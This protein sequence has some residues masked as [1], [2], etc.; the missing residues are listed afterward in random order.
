MVF[1]DVLL[2]DIIFPFTQKQVDRDLMSPILLQM[3]NDIKEKNLSITG[4][5]SLT[6]LTDFY[7]GFCKAHKAIQL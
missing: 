1:Q 7:I 2:K 3:Q 6:I 5:K 4:R